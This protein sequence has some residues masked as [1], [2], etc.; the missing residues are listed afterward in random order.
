MIAWMWTLAHEEAIL[1]VEEFDNAKSAFCTLSVNNI[2]P[3]HVSLVHAARMDFRRR[4]NSSK[5][6]DT[7]S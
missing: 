1:A 7:F 4:C 3:L 6:V 5:L 2:G